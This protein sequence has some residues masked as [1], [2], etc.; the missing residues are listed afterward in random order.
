LIESLEAWSDLAQLPN[1]S[2]PKPI[3][4]EAAFEQLLDAACV[5]QQ[6]ND[7][8]RAHD[9]LASP[10]ETISEIV[11]LQGHI[12]SG[13]L[14]FE[15]VASL[16]ASELLKT[17]NASGVA[18][19]LLEQDSLACIAATGD[20]TSLIGTRLPPNHGFSAQCLLTGAIQQCTEAQFDGNVPP[21]FR[22]RANVR[23]FIAAPIRRHT[24]VVGALEL[25]FAQPAAFEERDIRACEL[26]AVLLSEARALA[27]QIEIKAPLPNEPVEPQEGKKKASPVLEKF[28]PELTPIL[29]TDIFSSAWNEVEPS[30]G[31]IDAAEQI[32]EGHWQT[33]SAAAGS[34]QSDKSE[35]DVNPGFKPATPSGPA[36][37]GQNVCRGCGHDFSD[38]EAFCGRC[39]IS[40]IPAKADEGYLQHKWATLWY[41]QE[42]VRRKLNKEDSA[43]EIAPPKGNPPLEIEIQH[44]VSL[45]ESLR[46]TSPRPLVDQSGSK[47]D[48]SASFRASTEN[49]YAIESP[50]AETGV[51]NDLD[52]DVES[53]DDGRGAEVVVGKKEKES[54]V[55]SVENQDP[56]QLEPASAALWES[57]PKNPSFDDLL[58]DENI[59]DPQS[60]ETLTAEPNPL[61]TEGATDEIPARQ[62][63]RLR[64]LQAWQ[65][66]RATIYLSAAVIL[67][68]VTVFGW[69]TPAEL[70]ENSAKVQDTGGPELTALDKLLIASGLAEAPEP[71]HVYLG[72]PDT[73]VWLDVRTALYYCPGAALYGKTAGGRFAT[74]RGAQ[75]D[76]FEPATRKACD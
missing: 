17:T 28:S 21:S 73:Q 39:G 44:N 10:T 13:K 35:S 34:N 4:D 69:G 67:L 38:Q 25:W 2:R 50:S 51:D 37:S 36:A 43:S 22:R 23:S 53:G 71:P 74:Q 48:L 26:M 32:D 72:N 9:P 16:I 76:Q 8:V 24:A 3:V 45:P 61:P 6:H 54:A 19:S 33:E 40:R 1:H 42:A 46:S 29:G 60:A 62:T 55:A 18:I 14:D 58:L 47:P 68:M 56:A 11:E 31:A 49:V 27:S 5:M 12:Q 63:P 41:M 59:G 70:N 65:S 75:Q 30:T 64:I 20:A 7:R 15:A 66:H 52:N 57:R